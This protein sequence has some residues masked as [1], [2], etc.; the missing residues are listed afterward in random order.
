MNDND[1]FSP[2]NRSH[3]IFEQSTPSISFWGDVFRRY[4]SSKF[5]LLCLF[6]LVT[7]F[8]CSIFLPLIFDS[9]INGVI[10]QHIKAPPSWEFWWGADKFGHD[11]FINVWKG[12]QTSFLVGFTAAFLQILI[13]ILVG[14]CAGYYGG[15]IDLMLMRLIDVFISIPY[16]IV[17]LAIQV[18]MGSGLST[19]IFALVI[20][21]WLPVAR[22]VRGQI[23]QLKN[24]DFIMAAKALGVNGLNIMMRH[25]VPNIMGIVIVQLT[26][27]IPTAMFSEAFLSFI[28]LG[29]G[30]VSWGSLIR[31]GMEV[32]D[33]SMI[34][35]LGPSLLLAITMF[36]IQMNGDALRDALDPKLRS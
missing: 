27:S 18:V 20:T 32:R 19:I 4:K 10:Y 21:G 16:L 13:G 28:G 23:L 3:K 22:L 29:S 2:I 24:E 36:C 1:L 5:T 34:Q 35:L 26:L 14:C 33:T 7:I 11:V 9:R 8:L 25:F 6:L 17:V 30:A 31:T 12:G 15:K